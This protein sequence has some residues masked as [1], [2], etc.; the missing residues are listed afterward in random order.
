MFELKSYSRKELSILYFPN[1]SARG[2]Y[3]A[4]RK[5]LEEKKDKNPELLK[6]IHCKK[7]LPKP[8]VKQIVDLL[9]EP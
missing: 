6:D 3:L 7:I 9:G 4:L 1:S 2:A 5:W 8:L